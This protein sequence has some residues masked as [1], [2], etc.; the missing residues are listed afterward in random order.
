MK[1][2]LFLLKRILVLRS[3]GTVRIFTADP[4]RYACPEEITKFEEEVAATTIAA[5][6]ELGGLKVSQLPGPEA[7][8]S[9]GKKDGDTKMI[10]EGSQVSCYS[11]S[12]AERKWNKIGDVVGASGATQNTSGKVLHEGKVKCY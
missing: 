4:D 8:L 11:W 1:F 10:R 5:Q 9:E 12:A 6:Q 7:L 2:I 3:D